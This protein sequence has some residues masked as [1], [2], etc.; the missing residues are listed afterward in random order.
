MWRKQQESNRSDHHNNQSEW[1]SPVSDWLVVTMQPNWNYRFLN[2]LCVT[3]TSLQ[4]SGACSCDHM[5]LLFGTNRT[6]HDIRVVLMETWHVD[7]MWFQ[8]G[9]RRRLILHRLHHTHRHTRKHILNVTGLCVCV[10]ATASSRRQRWLTDDD[11]M[12]LEGE[13]ERVWSVGSV[14]QAVTALCILNTFFPS[15]AHSSA[16]HDEPITITHTHTQ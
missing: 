10:G 4:I 15:V 14:P 16:P 9:R 1:S 2:I 5:V 6:E 8:H 7:K 13:G 12:V 11:Q 3:L